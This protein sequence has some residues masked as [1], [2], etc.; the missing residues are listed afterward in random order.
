[1]SALALLF[2]SFKYNPSPILF[3]DEVDASLDDANVIRYSQFIR[4]LA[5]TTQVMMISHNA[6]TV[7]ASDALFGVTMAE[8]GISKL[9]TASIESV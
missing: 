7:E 9:V 4:R 3:L 8:P 6:L 5:R 1:L 2:A